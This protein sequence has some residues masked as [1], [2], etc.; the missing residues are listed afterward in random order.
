M[1]RAAWILIAL[2][3]GACTSSGSGRGGATPDTNRLT[4]WAEFVDYPTLIDRLPIL[5]RNR[6]ELNLGVTRG[7]H[8][9]DEM[10]E[11][12]RA[13]TALGVP[14]HIWP[15]LSN[16]DG[17]WPN[18]KNV[19]DFATYWRDLI[20]YITTN[21]LPVTTLVVD[22]ET[23][24]EKLMG[25]LDAFQGSIFDLI[26]AIVFFIDDYDAAVYDAGVVAFA[27]LVG[28][29]HAAGLK[30]HLTI[31]GLT[32]DDFADG[33][34]DMHKF[35]DLVIDGPD[36]DEVSYQ[37]YRTLVWDIIGAVLGGELWSSYYVYD[38]ALTLKER[39]G[40]RAAIDLGII[41][42]PGVE[43]AGY[44]DP[45]QLSE[46]I[47]AALAAGFELEDLDVFAFDGVIDDPDPDR[48]FVL[49]EGPFEAPEVDARVLDLRE[50]FRTIDT[51][52]DAA[53]F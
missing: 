29:A 16:A 46:D 15:E 24:Y 53:D 32:P 30:V 28:E 25:L 34:L 43:F 38:Y 36:W 21:R 51:A 14:V 19:A 48:W 8:T 40:D 17:K 52:L 33:D 50:I 13:G 20:D 39:F 27:D 26:G 5:A 47:A 22:M 42:T 37:L 11:V 49:P 7:E 4:M 6:A 18:V 9:F 3:A 35:F 23:S 12:V 41:E 10:A 31:P 45:R 2:A 1:K 44:T